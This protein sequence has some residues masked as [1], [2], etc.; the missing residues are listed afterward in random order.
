MEHWIERETFAGLTADRLRE[1]RETALE[2]MRDLGP[3]AF[4]LRRPLV[5][6]TATAP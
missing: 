3:V 1:L 2:R 5:S 6:V 4:V